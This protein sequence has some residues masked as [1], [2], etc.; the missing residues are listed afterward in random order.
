MN[1]HRAHSLLPLNTLV[2]RH[3]HACFPPYI[4]PSAFRHPDPVIFKEPVETTQP[5]QTVTRK[6]G[7][8]GR[9]SWPGAADRPIPHTSLAYWENRMDGIQ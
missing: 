3:V 7:S 9:I 1:Q 5:P 2:P 8:V 4:D 6:T